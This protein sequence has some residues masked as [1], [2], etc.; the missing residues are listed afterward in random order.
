MRTASPARHR[1]RRTVPLRVAVCPWLTVTWPVLTLM[2]GRSLPLAGRTTSSDS[3]PS[4]AWKKMW[5]WNSQPP[6]LAAGRDPVG[7]AGG[8]S[9]RIR[10]VSV[11]APGGAGN[12]DVV[13][14]LV[15][16]PGERLCATVRHVGQRDRLDRE[17]V[18]VEWVVRA[19]R[20][21]DGEL[22]RVAGSCVARRV[23]QVRRGLVVRDIVGRGGAVDA[24]RPS[25]VRERD[26]RRGVAG[27]R[28]AERRRIEQRA[29][30]RAE[31]RHG[32][33]G[34]RSQRRSVRRSNMRADT[35]VP[36]TA[37]CITGTVGMSEKPFPVRRV[38]LGP[39][40]QHAGRRRWDRGDD[41]GAGAGREHDLAVVVLRVERRP[42]ARRPP[43]PRCRAA[44]PRRRRG[45]AAL[46]S[47]LLSVRRRRMKRIA[48]ELTISRRR[49]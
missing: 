27:L 31:D 47:R 3:M 41:V 26:R 42:A 43:R 6:E 2:S 46:S 48:A 7:H 28:R 32:V 23:D 33:A 40:R 4:V 25:R 1:R 35:G 13:A 24:E 18:Q 17:P 45:S 49:P 34:C 37:R 15:V 21:R 20:V 44:R 10:N 29:G 38:V 11:K 39:H 36:V 19:G 30:R 9:I 22:Q 12:V 14:E 16:R 5:Q 8:R